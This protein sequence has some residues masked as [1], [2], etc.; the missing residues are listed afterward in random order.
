MLLLII[1]IFCTIICTMVLTII[2][3]KNNIEESGHGTTLLVL[4]ILIG[5]VVALIQIARPQ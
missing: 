2:W 1:L 4:L 3:I 5:L